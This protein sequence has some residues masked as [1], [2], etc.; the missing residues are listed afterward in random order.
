MYRV[1]QFSLMRGNVH[2][3]DSK[4]CSNAGS[5]MLFQRS[6]WLC[7]KVPSFSAGNR[8]FAQ[9]RQVSRIADY[10]KAELADMHLAYGAVDCYEPSRTAF[11]RATISNEAFS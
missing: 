9:G 5:E 11:A 8:H 1:S 7:A 6:R 3:D 2:L 10:T 4:S